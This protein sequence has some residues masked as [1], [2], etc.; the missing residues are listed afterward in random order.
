MW[1]CFFPDGCPPADAKPL[2]LRVFR[3]VD[4]DPPQDSDFVS[5]R[6]SSPERRVSD[7]ILS[8]GLSC[9][10]D[11]IHAQKQS[12]SLVKTAY[13]RKRNKPPMMVASGDTNPQ[14]GVVKK[15]PSSLESHVT[16]WLLENVSICN[17]F[18][19]I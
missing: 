13:W 2:K 8:C 17:Q 9:Y 5:V 14:C 3:L 11:L 15:T 10:T 6:E 4:N 19:V 1:P 16:Y 7:V 18:K 12:A